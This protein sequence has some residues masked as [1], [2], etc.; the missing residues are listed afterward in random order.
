MS[1]RGSSL[2]HPI[3]IIAVILIVCLILWVMLRMALPIGKAM[4][5]LGLNIA[6]P[7]LG[8]LLAAFAVEIMANGLKQLFPI[9][10]KL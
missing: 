6:N 7:I 4:G 2:N 1:D 10:S 8:L 5:T 3:I 9:L